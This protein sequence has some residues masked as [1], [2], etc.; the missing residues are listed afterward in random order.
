AAA[1]ASH[2]RGGPLDTA[3][4]ARC[5]DGDLRHRPRSA[6]RG[7][8]RGGRA[9]TRWH[10]RGPARGTAAVVRA[11]AGR[12]RRHRPVD[13]CAS[14]GGKAV[15]GRTEDEV[16]AA[17][18]TGLEALDDARGAVPAGLM[19]DEVGRVVAVARGVATVSGLP[20]VVAGET[21]TLGHGAIGL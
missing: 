9:A 8:A 5:A 13:R 18:L 6:S 21:V 15:T 17:L 2:R 14:H 7:G 1:G 11:G 12:R 19:L 20:G 3:R 4:A 10:R 16:G